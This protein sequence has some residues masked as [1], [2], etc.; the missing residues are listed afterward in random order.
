MRIVTELMFENHLYTFNGK[1][2]RQRKGGP[3]RLRGTCAIARLVMCAW[4]RV[5]LGKMVKNNITIASYLRYMDDGRA[6]LHPFRAG[7]RW[8]D[9]GVKYTRRWEIEDMGKSG[10]EITRQVLEHSMQEVFPFL[11]FITGVGEGDGQWLP[12]LDTMVRIESNNIVSYKY[13]EKPTTTNAMVQKRSALCEN[14]KSQILSNELMR[15][16]SNTDV[17]QTDK[18][19]G[20]VIDQ[21][22]KKLLTSGYTYKQTRRIVLNGIRGWER[23]LSRSREDG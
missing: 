8:K 19:M 6:F 15:R 4:D 23:K 14:S 17:R 18:V 2:Y 5:W 13:Y 22:G 11:T 9:G 10:V 21:F 12:T 7:W 1:V 16:M 3:I 20:E